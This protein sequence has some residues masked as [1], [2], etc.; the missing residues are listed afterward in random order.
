[1]SEPLVRLRGIR[2][3]FAMG[4]Q[5]VRALDGI[6]LDI[7]RG[8]L[9]VLMGPS[10][11]G[12]SSLL[13]LIGALDA[14]SAGSYRLDGREVTTL[15]EPERVQ[16]R[17]DE[18]GFVFQSFHLVAR[19]TALRNVE[20]PMIFAGVPRAERRA[21]AARA[22]EELGLATRLAHRPD[23]LSGG[24]RQRVA[25]AR[26]LVMDPPLI[27]AD[28]PTGNLDSASGAEVVRLFVELNARGKTIVIVTHSDEVARIGQRVVRLR[29]GRLAA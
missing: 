26:A 3:E 11:C 4:D 8:E 25:I 22:L 28:E 12:K 19:M 14:P 23:E 17:R 5:I 24:E 15:S 2:R 16:L 18:V 20:L 29:D 10:G 21:R 1:M 9:L 13:N 6:D 27:L 7:G